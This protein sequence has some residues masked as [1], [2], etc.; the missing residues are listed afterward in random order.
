[1]E[2]IINGDLIYEWLKDLFP[3]HRSLAGPGNRKT[4]RYLKSKNKLLRIKGFNSGLKVFDWKIVDECSVKFAYIKNGNGKKILDYKDNNLHLVSFSQPLKKKCGLKE[5]KK[6]LYTIPERKKSIPYVTSYYKKNSGFCST[7]EFKSGLKEDNYEIVIDTKFKK[8]VMNYGEILIKG[9][10]S[11]EI[12]LTSNICH[13]SLANNELSGPC[14]LTAI[15]MWLQKQ[16]NLKFSYRLI[17]IPETIGSIAYIAKHFKKLRK[18]TIAGYVLTC[19]GDD[20]NY[21][22]LKSRNGN[23]LS[24][25]VALK[26]LNKITNK[27][28]VYSFTDRGSDERQFCSPKIDLPIGTLMRTKYREY[29]EYHTSDDNINFVSPKGLYGG[30]DYVKSCIQEL[31]KTRLYVSN[32]LCEPFLSKKKLYSAISNINSKSVLPSKNLLNCIT[33]MDGKNDIDYL[34]SIFKIDVSMIKKYIKILEQNNIIQ[35]I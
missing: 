22:Y 16:K 29:K 28:R 21:S 27:P 2:K 12:L 18:D 10:S 20:N 25:R 24:D 26:V 9:K 19:I 35:E 3:I 8:G 1:M 7:H 23:T 15:S 17:F 33:Y 5:L 30:Y 6:Y 13:P 14:V 4:L 31:E 32:Y 11:K 34:S